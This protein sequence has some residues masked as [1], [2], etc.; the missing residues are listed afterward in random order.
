MIILLL[1]SEVSQERRHLLE[2]SD[3]VVS[4]DSE[5]LKLEVPRP[6]FITQGASLRRD[7]KDPDPVLILELAIGSLPTLSSNWTWGFRALADCA[8]LPVLSSLGDLS[9]RTHQTTAPSDSKAPKREHESPES[10][11]SVHRRYRQAMG[12]TPGVSHG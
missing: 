2:S 6:N 9:M 3:I 8:V 7:R 4:E 1:F 11:P 10:M 5:V 12:A